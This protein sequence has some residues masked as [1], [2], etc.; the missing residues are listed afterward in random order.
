MVD[1]KDVMRGSASDRQI[2]ERFERQIKTFKNHMKA[3]PPPAREVLE[4]SVEAT[5]KCAK[6]LGGVRAVIHDAQPSFSHASDLEI[7]VALNCR[8]AEC[9]WT[10]NQ[11]R[12]WVRTKP[13]EL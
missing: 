4:R 5:T 10:S 11:W 6:C 12:P 13:T 2:R 8:N 9:G 7:L 3:Y 1:K